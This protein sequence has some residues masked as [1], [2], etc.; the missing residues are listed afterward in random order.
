MGVGVGR[1]RGRRH[2]RAHEHQHEHR[3]G[4][5]GGHQHRHGLGVVSRV[6]V[7]VVLGVDM[8]VGVHFRA[9]NRRQ[10]ESPAGY[11][12]D[13]AHLEKDLTKSR[14]QDACS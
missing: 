1:G 9:F 2:G 7:E 5:E 4:R 3:H 10:P 12:G 8:G 11:E 14:F 6:G 13:A